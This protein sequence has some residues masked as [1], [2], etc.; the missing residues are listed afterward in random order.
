MVA[1]ATFRASR[2][3]PNE[4]SRFKDAELAG[5]IVTPP[6]GAIGRGD[7][8]ILKIA[9]R[10]SGVVLSNDSFQEF[11]DEYPWLFDVGRLI[12]GK[13]VRGVGWVFTPRLP[14]RN[15]KT[16]RQREETRGDVVR[17]READHRHDVDARQGE[18]GPGRRRRRPR[19]RRFRARVD[20]DRLRDREADEEGRQ[21]V[22]KKST[23]LEGRQGRRRS[24]RRRRRWKRCASRQRRRSRCDGGASPSIPKRTS[25]HLR[26]PIASVR[27]SRV[28]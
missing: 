18:E 13:P 2:R 5:E 7:A 22:T 4:R 25:P 12:G 14:V 6:A 27:A 3:R 19:P 15:T 11:H 1:D 24:R 17:W 8:F 28:K 20:E 9:D 10:I 16:S 26:A 23:S 21:E